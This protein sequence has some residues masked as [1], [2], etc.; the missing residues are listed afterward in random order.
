MRTAV[1]EDSLW[2]D[3]FQTHEFAILDHAERVLLD[4]GPFDLTFGI[5]Q[6]ST[7]SIR[8]T[9]PLYI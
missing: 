3:A 2:R 7:F 9:G 8:M 4:M 5:S 6:T 1:A